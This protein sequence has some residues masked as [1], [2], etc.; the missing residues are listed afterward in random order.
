M[1]DAHSETYKG[2][3]IKIWYDQDAESP[4]DWDNLG[5][6]LC[7]HGRYT[8]GDKDPVYQADDQ[9]G[10]QELADK[11]IKEQHAA[12]I[13]PLYLF[14]HGGITISTGKF[15]CP[16]D[17]G[18]VGFV[19]VTREK[20][21]KEFGGKRVSKAM[22]KKAEAILEGEVETYDH[23]LRG[24]CYGYT[25][26]AGEGDD[27]GDSSDSCGGYLGDY[28]NEEYGALREARSAVDHEV[29]REFKKQFATAMVLQDVM[30]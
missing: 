4:R 28:D 26:Y 29:D 10:W 30:E 8:L 23:F 2:Y 6:M 15:S 24:D 5:T 14:D 13:L 3:T 9:S 7:F 16:W 27:L 25:I 20:L 11:L 1:D 22:L 19:Y 18:Q 21:L 17:S 12:V